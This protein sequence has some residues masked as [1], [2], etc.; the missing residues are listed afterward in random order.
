MDPW[1]I[2]GDEPPAEEMVFSSKSFQLQNKI[3]KSYVSGG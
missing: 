3:Q 2:K 1:L